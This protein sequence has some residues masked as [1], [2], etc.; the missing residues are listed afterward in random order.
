MD[1][2]PV[3]REI[4]KIDEW[5]AASGMAESRLGLLACANPRAVERVRNGTG[6]VDTLRALVDYVRRNPA[7]RDG[8]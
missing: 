8:K 1:E 2:N 5:L 3:D 4:K 6:S 7:H